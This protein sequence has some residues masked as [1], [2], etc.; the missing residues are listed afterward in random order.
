MNKEITELPFQGFCWSNINVLLEVVQFRP[1]IFETVPKRTMHRFQLSPLIK[2][3]TS[4]AV[5]H[6]ETARRSNANNIKRIAMLEGI[7]ETLIEEDKAEFDSNLAESLSTEKLFKNYTN[8]N[9]TTIP[10]SVSFENEIAD[11]PVR[12][13]SLFSKY[14]ASIFKMEKLESRGY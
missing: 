11:D 2:P 14:I 3:P 5:K 9:S 7:A 4:K 1:I 10:S 12:Q 6:I 13:C 8:F